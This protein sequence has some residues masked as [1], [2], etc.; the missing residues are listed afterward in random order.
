MIVHLSVNTQGVQ[1][2]HTIGIPIWVST[3]FYIGYYYI[4]LGRY[5]LQTI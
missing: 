5:T 4:T 2:E 3:V 1:K